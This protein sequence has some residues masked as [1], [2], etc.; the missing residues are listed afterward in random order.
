M[1]VTLCKVFPQRCLLLH[2]R[3]CIRHNHSPCQIWVAI[4]ARLVPG[5][6]QVQFTRSVAWLRTS[7]QHRM[8]LLQAQHTSTQEVRQSAIREEDIVVLLLHRGRGKPAGAYF[9]QQFSTAN[10]TLLPLLP[11]DRIHRPRVTSHLYFPL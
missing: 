9:N 7:I 10:L 4:T 6:E 5:P 1:A 11:R 2:L 8:T 3:C